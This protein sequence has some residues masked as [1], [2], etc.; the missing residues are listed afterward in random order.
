MCRNTSCTHAQQQD[1][2]T[3]GGLPQTLQH[4]S[5]HVVVVVVIAALI[6]V[7]IP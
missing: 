4:S 7:F 5:F 1:K 6:V 3:Q 2:T